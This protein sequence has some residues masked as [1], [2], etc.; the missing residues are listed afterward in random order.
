MCPINGKIHVI[1]GSGD[2]KMVKDNGE[3]SAV[4]GGIVEG[5]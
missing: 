2:H 5:S 3:L 4:V 1:G